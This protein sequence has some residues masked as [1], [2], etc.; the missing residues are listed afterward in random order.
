MH[1]A[2]QKSDHNSKDDWHLN[3]ERLTAL[4]VNAVT[5]LLSVLEQYCKNRT[6]NETLKSKPQRNTSSFGREMRYPS[7]VPQKGLAKFPYP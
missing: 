3:Q 6:I 5:V 4:S 2:Y 7:E 1:P